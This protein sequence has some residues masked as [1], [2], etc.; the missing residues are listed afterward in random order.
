MLLLKQLAVGKFSLNNKFLLPVF[1]R[2]L[3]VSSLWMTCWLWIL[4][5][6]KFK[7]K[8][9]L[10]GKYQHYFVGNTKVVIKVAI[11]LIAMIF[12]TRLQV[13]STRVGGVPEVLPDDMIKL[14]EPSVK[15]KL[16]VSIKWFNAWKK[17]W[18]TS[19]C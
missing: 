1:D 5:V 18:V 4:I 11:P 2:H 6:F 12:Y 14:A 3:R 13:V 16:N 10:L 9:L 7:L 17:P 15:C 8:P 19:L